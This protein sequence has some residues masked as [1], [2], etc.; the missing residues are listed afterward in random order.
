M[1][2]RFYELAPDYAVGAWVGEFCSRQE[3]TQIMD[4]GKWVN[5]DDAWHAWCF[6]LDDWCGQ[7][8][9]ENIGAED[10]ATEFAEAYQGTW[11]DVEDWAEGLMTDCGYLPTSQHEDG[12]PLLRFVDWSQ[13]VEWLGED[14]TYHEVPNGTAI[15]WRHI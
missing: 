3:F 11:R 9:A 15:T 4:D 1:N 10:L 2:S 13:V 12:N 5:D 6:W 7:E 14:Y 8:Y